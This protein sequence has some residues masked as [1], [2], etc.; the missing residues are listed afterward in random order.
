MVKVVMV[1]IVERQQPR[2]SCDV[3]RRAGD[4]IAHSL[5]EGGNLPITTISRHE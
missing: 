1:P 3:Q 2:P 4:M 5:S